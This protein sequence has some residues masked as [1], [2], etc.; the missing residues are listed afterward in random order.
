MS[1]PWGTDLDLRGLPGGTNLVLGGAEQ[2]GSNQTA[3]L[4]ARLPAPHLAAR[5]TVR[6]PAQVA[7]RLPAPRL[8]LAAAVGVPVQLAA[9]LPAPRLATQGALALP[10]RLTARLPAPRLVATIG[11]GAAARL[12]ARLPAPRLAC[13]ATLSTNLLS[14]T[15][16]ATR[17][18][19]HPAA[20]LGASAR[21]PLAD[22]PPCATA[23]R[24]PWRRAAPLTQE[25]S[26]AWRDTD[27]QVS[28]A[29]CVVWRRAPPV[30]HA[31]PNTWRG[32]PRHNQGSSS[33]WRAA[34]LC[35]GRGR[36]R[37]RGPPLGTVGAADT[38]QPA[39]R[40]LAALC[41]SLADGPPLRIGLIEHWR[42]A[43]LV[44]YVWRPRAFPPAPPPPWVHWGTHLCLHGDPGSMALDLGG[45]PCPTGP[46]RIPTRRSYHVL[47]DFSVT[48]L[49]DG[50]PVGATALRISL[51]ADAWGWSWSG[52]L[53]GA[54]ALEAVLPSEQGE[55]VTLVA[56]LDG[57]VWHLLVEDWSEDASFG[58]RAVQ[59][60]GRGLA[61][62]L[63]DPSELPV[64]GI[65]QQDR[66]LQQALSERLP[67]GSP[68]SLSFAAGT[69]DWLLPA[70]AWSWSNATPIA[71]IHAACQAVGL[72]VIPAAA[73]RTLTV[74]PRYPVL[75]WLLAEAE[76]D[77]IVPESAILRRTRGRRVPTQG[78][79][80]WV[81]GGETGGILARVVRAGSAGDRAVEMRQCDLITHAD[82][83]RLL[84]GR[85][86]AAQE[87]QPEVRSVQLPLGGDVPLVPLGAILDIGTVR[88]IVSGISVEVDGT[89][90]AQ[91]VTVG[92]DTGNR[93]A[94]W[95]RLT[96]GSPLLSGQVSEASAGLARVGLPGTG[97]VRAR[98]RGDA[99]A[100][101]SRVWMQD[102]WVQG[103]APTLEPLEIE[104]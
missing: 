21:A 96:P 89:R 27:R 67:F 9:R 26:S 50:L 62:E 10:V 1:G 24:A 4:A 60:S 57:N 74:Q 20:G 100:I 81:Q 97:T 12:V 79:V 48:R 72:V 93:W 31:A 23:T 45:L 13:P 82:G 17:A 102:G 101:G 19:W 36:D 55:P 58:E 5:A 34:A 53:A 8:A 86:L 85:I 66:T 56:D 33:T 80:V 22:A 73:A 28:P 76:P 64:S 44:Y 77:L 15:I 35:T 7:A 11:S 88:A 54:A 6:I 25:G 37:W 30:A 2:G 29:G 59:V 90:C 49:S 103:G 94:A 41:T 75:P 39:A 84:G 61:A 46:L 87:Q 16:G 43:R 78:N 92:E 52:T 32:G 83:A 18:Q 99:P 42:D 104:V 38:W 3:G 68:W 91:V 70:G 69:P 14:D 51:D 98:Y 47:H 40:A 71:T 95:K 63:A 65:L